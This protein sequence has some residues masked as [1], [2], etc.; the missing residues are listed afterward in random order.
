MFYLIYYSKI[1][2][3]V[4]SESR[5]ARRFHVL[6]EH[7]GRFFASKDPHLSIVLLPL[8]GVSFPRF[9]PL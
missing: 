9:D 8:M 2:F 4:I 1:P 3:I 6:K 7:I 5:V